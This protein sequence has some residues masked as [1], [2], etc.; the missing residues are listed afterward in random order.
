MFLSSGGLWK[1]AGFE[2]ALSLA[3][4]TEVE[5]RAGVSGGVVRWEGRAM[6]LRA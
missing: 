2:F 5:V 1:L 6:V 4:S 3:E